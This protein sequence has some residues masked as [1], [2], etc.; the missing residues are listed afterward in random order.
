MHDEYK[1]NQARWSREFV[2]KTFAATMLIASVENEPLDHKYIYVS[3]L[4]KANDWWPGVR[5]NNVAPSDFLLQRNKGDSI[6]VRGVIK[7][8]SFGTIVL[9]NCE[10][11][12]KDLAAAAPSP[13]KKAELTGSSALENK[14]EPLTEP[15]PPSGPETPSPPRPSSEAL[16]GSMPLA[17]EAL[18]SA[19][20]AARQAYESA[21][22][23]LLKGT[24]RVQRGKESVRQ[25]RTAAQSIG[26]ERC[27]SYR[28]TARGRACWQLKLPK[29]YMPRL[30]TTHYPTCWMIPL[31]D[32]LRQYFGKSR[33]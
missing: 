29:G 19:V 8:A 33:A 27:P 31:S 20:Q 13:Q 15:A 1:A 24:A 32:R 23:D 14:N 25:S 5:C 17:E 18:I 7:D 16:P 12:M 9:E 28:Q 3:F 6:F 21:T 30:G 22:N 4:E 10:F 26:W 2:G 11:S